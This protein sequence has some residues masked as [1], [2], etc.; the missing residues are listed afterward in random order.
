MAS[1]MYELALQL[2]QELS[3]ISSKKGHVVFRTLKGETKFVFQFEKNHAKGL[4]IQLLK[5]VD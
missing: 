2:E 1:S 4:V 5:N 3:K